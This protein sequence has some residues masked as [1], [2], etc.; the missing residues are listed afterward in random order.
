MVG[1]AGDGARKLYDC[2]NPCD[3]LDDPAWSPDGA[4]IAA[5]KMTDSGDGHLGSLVGIDVETGAETML[6]TFAPEDLCGGPRWSPD[7]SEISFELA[8]SSGHL[9]PDEP[10][11]VT[12]SVVDLSDGST[13]DPAAHRSGR[14]SRS[15][16]DWNPAGDLIVYSALPTPDA[17]TPE[18]F[19]IRPDGSDVRQ[20]T[21]LAAEGSSAIEPT[22]DLDGASVVFVDESSGALRRVDLATGAVT[23]AFTKD[24]F[25][26]H[27]SP[28]P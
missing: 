4:S 5:C 24:T 25:A 10:I 1:V 16:G 9:A 2:E 21:N 26:N 28:R 8:T 6:A 20:L 18:L 17:E 7:G 22:F 12:L 14:S 19:T 23:N 27:P 11:A 13:R 15:W 3:Y